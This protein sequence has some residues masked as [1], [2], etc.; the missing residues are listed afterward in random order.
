MVVWRKSRS[1]RATVS[2][3]RSTT[4]VLSPCLTRSDVAI[5]SSPDKE[6]WPESSTRGARE[7]EINKALSEPVSGPGFVLPGPVV[8]RRSLPTENLVRDP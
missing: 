7:R 2:Y 3:T 4:F 1:C 6:T 8:M 5:P